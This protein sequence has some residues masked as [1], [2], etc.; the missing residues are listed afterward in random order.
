MLDDSRR[1]LTFLGHD[2]IFF[3]KLLE[4]LWTLVDIM[5]NNAT[6]ISFK[7]WHEE[8]WWKSANIHDNMRTL[9]KLCITQLR[10]QRGF[11]GF[12]V[13]KIP[14]THSMGKLWI[15]GYPGDVTYRSDGVS[16]TPNLF[17]NS[18]SSNSRGIPSK[19]TKSTKTQRK[20]LIAN[21]YTHKCILIAIWLYNIYYLQMYTH[22]HVCTYIYI[23]IYIIIYICICIC[24][25]VC[26]YTHMYICK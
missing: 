2:S 19:S 22:I 8:T 17:E 3:G 9:L 7:I 25:C 4:T 18:P 14:W 16:S 15:Q 10:F 21:V 23:Y 20:K 11:W 12:L 13:N 26:T 6:A 5:V 1:T 24:I